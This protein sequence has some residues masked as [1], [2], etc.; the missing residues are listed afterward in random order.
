MKQLGST[1]VKLAFFALVATTA[2][3]AS[4]APAAADVKVGALECNVSG[5]VGLIVTSHRSLSCTFTSV[6]GWRE[7]YEGRIR[8]FGLDIGKTSRGLLAWGV[9]APTSGTP[10]HALA[11]SYVGVS[12]SATLGAGVGAN[13]L[14]GGF[15]RSFTLQPFSIEAQTGLALS[16]G[17]SAME[18]R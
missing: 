15:R 12:G 9:F 11:G 3:L 4:L 13:A 6:E 10:R 5:S 1:K 8:N 14:V 17:V 16:A 18:L 2:T 7:R